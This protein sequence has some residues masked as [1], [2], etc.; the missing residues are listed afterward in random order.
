VDESTLNMLRAA[1]DAVIALIEVC[2]KSGPI[3]GRDPKAV[4]QVSLSQYLL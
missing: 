4:A 1:E 3:Y 2:R